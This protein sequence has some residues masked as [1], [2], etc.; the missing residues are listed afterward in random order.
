MVMH[1][2]FMPVCTW[3]DFT[4]LFF[5]SCAMGVAGGAATLALVEVAARVIWGSWI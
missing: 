5:L 1:P 4:G 2:V 3:R